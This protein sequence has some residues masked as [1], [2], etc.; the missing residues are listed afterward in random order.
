LDSTFDINTPKYIC[1][2][3]ELAYKLKKD[4]SNYDIYEFIIKYSC[5]E[6]N[7]SNIGIYKIG[8]KYYRDYTI[9]KSIKLKKV[10]PR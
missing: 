5:S 8:S 2:L 7:S 3:I 4:S 1:S 10:C 9:P 6:T